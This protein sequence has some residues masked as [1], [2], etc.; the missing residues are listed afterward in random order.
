MWSSRPP[1]WQV[2]ARRATSIEQDFAAE[3]TPA[4]MVESRSMLA[5]L[6]EAVSII[7]AVDPLVAR[8]GAGRAQDARESLQL[9]IRLARLHG[10][11]FDLNC[12]PEHDGIRE[13]SLRL[14]D[15]YLT[16]LRYLHTV[17]R[18]APS[19]PGA[20]E[21]RTRRTLQV[22]GLGSPA[23]RLIEL[24]DTLG[25]VLAERRTLS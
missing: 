13:D 14:L 5:I 17:R 24:R 23:D 9:Q 18:P 3:F 11:L 8:W 2:R 4:C 16:M 15:F 21:P 12:C 25:A 7:D 22:D 1:F 19:A 20:G 6:D 10:W